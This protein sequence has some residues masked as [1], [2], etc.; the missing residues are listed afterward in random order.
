[1]RSSRSPADPK[2]R[3][4]L[5]TG[6]AR[7]GCSSPTRPTAPGRPAAAAMTLAR[8]H[9]RRSKSASFRGS[10][11]EKARNVDRADGMRSRSTIEDTA[12]GSCRRI[13][14]VR[15][16]FCLKLLL[17]PSP[18]DENKLLC[19]KFVLLKFKSCSEKN[20]INSQPMSVCIQLESF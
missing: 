12:W 9:G 7:R 14:P 18:S 19:N 10:H 8:R 13:H 1:M 2:R 5:R 4:H 11:K 17:L 16:F 6:S 20:H 3:W 15:T